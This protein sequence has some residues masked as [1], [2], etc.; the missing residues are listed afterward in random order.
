MADK[1]FKLVEYRA[2]WLEQRKR[3]QELHYDPN[4][5]AVDICVQ[6]RPELSGTSLIS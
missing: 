5:G 6:G 4:V 2:E 3:A 1:E